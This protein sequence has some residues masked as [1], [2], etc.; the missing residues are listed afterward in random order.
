MRRLGQPA[1][2]ADH[3]ADYGAAAAQI[4]LRYPQA[5]GIEIWLEPNNTPFWG[6]APNPGRYADLVRATTSA[7]RATGSSM[8]LITGGLAPGAAAS[9]KLE[10]GEFLAQA[11]AHGGIE[12]ADSIGFDAVTDTPFTSPDDPT[13][14]YLGRLR[15]QIQELHA[16]L[17]S[18]GAQRPIAILELAYSTRRR[19]LQ[20]GPA[21]PGA[22]R[23][24]RRPAPD[25]RRP[26]RHRQPAVRQRRRVEG[27]G[28]RRPASERVAEDRLLPARE[29]CRR[30]QAAGLLSAAGRRP[31][32]GRREGPFRGPLRSWPVS[33][34]LSCTAIHLAGS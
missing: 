7:V 2:A 17:A 1:G 4:A 32:R 27:R 5:A 9:T 22:E 25:R 8:P 23:E 10:F 29:R 26:A 31:D 16:K 30:G 19:R 34:I 3:L 21:V 12:T 14:G 6:A 33:R 11:L 13:A 20:R 28:L 15:V 24:P 18:A